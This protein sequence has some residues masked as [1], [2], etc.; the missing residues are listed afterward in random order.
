MHM[1]KTAAERRAQPFVATGDILIGAEVAEVQRQ[2]Q[3]R[4][5]TVDADRAAAGLRRAAI[6]ATGSVTAVGDVIWLT[7][8]IRVRVVNASTMAL[9]VSAAVRNGSGKV[10]TF[11]SAPT[12]PHRRSQMC[13]TAPYS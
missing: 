11:N 2:L 6:A 7:I 5:R 1:Q 3:H 8:S 10:T 9:T 4:V 12:S 13:L